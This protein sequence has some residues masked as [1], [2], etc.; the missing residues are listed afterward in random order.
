MLAL[1]TLVIYSD[2][3]SLDSSAEQQQVAHVHN[4]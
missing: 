3:W 4:S 1:K 2:F